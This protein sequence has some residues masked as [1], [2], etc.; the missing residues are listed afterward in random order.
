MT[1]AEGSNKERNK[2]MKTLK[3][4]IIRK[5]GGVEQT[6]VD[7]TISA[8]VAERDEFKDKYNKLKTKH[9]E[10]VKRVSEDYEL[11]RK[12]DGSGVARLIQNV[13]FHTV[14]DTIGDRLSPMGG[15]NYSDIAE[16]DILIRDYAKS[17]ASEISAF[18]YG[19]KLRNTTEPKWGC[20]N[21]RTGVSRMIAIGGGANSL[22][23]RFARIWAKMHKDHRQKDLLTVEQIKLWRSLPT[24]MKTACNIAAKY[25]HSIWSEV[26][27]V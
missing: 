16:T 27:R 6:E 23:G 3:N 24:T 8:L 12:E 2:E 21:V 22:I 20:P 17:V 15:A 18:T 14:Q 9:E 25:Y 1:I 26:Q 19:I 4:W 13:L 11:N 10:Y 5:L 7:V